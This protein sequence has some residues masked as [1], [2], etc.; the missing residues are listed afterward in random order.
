MTLEVEHHQT[1]DFVVGA[2]FL[3]GSNFEEAA[4]WCAGEV[5][6][7]DKPH[8]SKP[9]HIALLV[10][11]GVNPRQAKAWEGEWIVEEKN[12]LVIY[13]Q[14]NYRRV[15]PEK[16]HVEVVEFFEEL[17]KTDVKDKTPI[18][19]GTLTTNLSDEAKHKLV[20]ILLESLCWQHEVLIR[21]DEK[22]NTPQFVR[23]TVEQIC[24]MFKV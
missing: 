18:R 4:L 2:V 5:I 24:E 16:G 15:Y 23:S 7:T 21:T 11:D 10:H 17:V 12:G 19:Q 6:L 13:S 1:G 3:D 8:S 14:F 9:V 22:F 20:R